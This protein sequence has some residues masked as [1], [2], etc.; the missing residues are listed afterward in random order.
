MD[1]INNDRSRVQRG[2]QSTDFQ[3]G[4]GFKDNE[5]I[6]IIVE[7]IKM[8]AVKLRIKSIKHHRCV[9][10][11][12]V[13]IKERSEEDIRRILAYDTSPTKN[14]NRTEIKCVEGKCGEKSWGWESSSIRGIRETVE[15]FYQK[16]GNIEPWTDSESLFCDTEFLTKFF[17][18]KPQKRN[19][20]RD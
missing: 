1:S 17:G 4:G 14:W 20:Y 2:K 8:G 3:L 19:E 12:E 7:L 11:Q 5:V 6:E 9:A 16:H 18:K 13:N 10:E 15:H